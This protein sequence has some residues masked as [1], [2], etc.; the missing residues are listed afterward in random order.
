MSSVPPK[1]ETITIAKYI[2][3]R[4]VQLNV[5]SMFGVPGDFNLAFLDFV[6]DDEDIEWIGNCNEL[7]ATYA[8][9]GYAR[10][11][12][13]CN[14]QSLGVVT[15]TFGV[16]ELSAINGIAGAFSEH[17]PVLHIVGV[18][19][20]NQQKT[21]PMLHHTLGDGRFEAY[22]IAAEQFTKCQAILKDSQNAAALIDRVITDCVVWVES[23][24]IN[25]IVDLVIKA[26][27]DVAILVDG[28]VL[29]HHAVQETRDFITS[30]GFPVYSAP[31][32]KSIISETYERFGG[33]YNGQSTLPEVL[34]S[35]ESSRLIISIGSI[36]S[37]YNTGNFTYHLPPSATIELHSDH[38]KLGFAV[39]S[40]VGM[41][42]LLPKLTK[43]L[44][45]I[46]ARGRLAP[47]AKWG[48]SVPPEDNPLIT[49]VWLWPRMGRF[50]KETDVILVETGTSSFG[51]LEICLPDHCI[52]A[53][54]ILWGS[55]GWSVG[56]TL[57][58]ALAA[59][60]RGLGRV[61]LFVGDGSLQLT[62]QEL[63][64]MIK[65]KLKPIIFVLNN[66]GYTV[67][68]YLHGEKRKYNDIENWKWTEL[69]STFGGIE[70]QTCC[71]YKVETKQ[72]LS[73]LLDSNHFAKA[74][75]I[76]VVEIL[77]DKFD[78]PETLKTVAELSKKTQKTNAN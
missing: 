12:Q 27:G 43:R 54:Q 75:V 9:D 4:L 41:K 58:A 53:A 50:I 46:D 67:E 21:R 32:G 77:L 66:R 31:M 35:V 37:D 45:A 48:V 23:F 7:N 55:I 29:R 40:G 64:T 69:L 70:G 56:A 65:W 1:E 63:S 3:K 36:K 18:P 5:R 13:S 72:E 15:T 76:Q 42:H 33:I 74:E 8:A 52:Y 60:E 73:T 57:G 59:R 39:F 10:I 47:V 17:I 34:K 30:T 22:T 14:S 51:A 26:G 19:S 61:C 2:L 71:S 62:V 6:E 44:G 78:A 38:T 25:H 11:A 68:R 20:T 16:G 24:V 49:H 28:C